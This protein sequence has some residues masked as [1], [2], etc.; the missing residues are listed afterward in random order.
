VFALL[1]DGAVLSALALYSLASGGGSAMVAA[2]MWTVWAFF[3][4]LVP[5]LLYTVGG[6][7][8]FL[9][10]LV[11]RRRVSLF[12]WV[13]ALVAAVVMVVMVCGATVG[14][15]KTRVEEVEICSSRV[16]AAFDG[17]R[18]VQFSDLHIGTMMRPV[19]RI[20]RVAE[21][22]AAQSPDMVVFTGD[23]VNLEHTELTGEVIK[24]LAAI[25]APDGVRM[26]WGNHDLGFYIRPG[27]SLTYQANFEAMSEKIGVIG[28]E[29][30]S[31]RS[32]YLYRGA[33][34]IAL[35]GV[36]YPRDTALNSHNQSLAGVDISAAFA[37]VGSE[38]FNVVLAHT[39]RLWSRIVEGGGGDLTLS[40]HVHAMQTKVRL[41]RKTWSPAR[42]MYREWSGRYNGTKCG[43]NSVLYIND[44]I[45]CVGYPMR[46][47]ARGEITVITLKRCE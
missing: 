6:V 4:T 44:G 19:R 9:V 36:D 39:P 13:G 7:V 34:S 24:A 21:A 10:R 2:I 41:G 20:A 16:P 32:T 42:Y 30:L 31:D 15:L 45:G 46:I 33:D 37:G 28:W 3:L 23:L 8:D 12:R 40:G 38:V 14:R 26:A 29:I 11:L 35:T 47:G 1:T 27:S 18:I 43:K 17:Y 5:K 25:T 22:I